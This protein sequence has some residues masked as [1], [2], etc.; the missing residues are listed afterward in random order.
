ML[1]GGPVFE[2]GGGGAGRAA[3]GFSREGWVEP[4]VC[5]YGEWGGAGQRPGRSSGETPWGP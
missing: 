4:G 2:G 3:K 5:R 1:G